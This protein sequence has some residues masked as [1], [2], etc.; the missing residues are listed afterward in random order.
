MAN[1]FL[2]SRK[3]MQ[4]YVGGPILV[5][6]GMRMEAEQGRTSQD[7][8]QVGMTLAEAHAAIADVMAYAADGDFGQV[9]D[10]LSEVVAFWVGQWVAQHVGDEEAQFGIT[11]RL[12]ASL[13]AGAVAFL[14]AHSE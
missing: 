10:E 2:E 9:M 1:E 4:E 13:I 14:E 11:A 7:D 8:P 5:A 6:L 3:S 12:A